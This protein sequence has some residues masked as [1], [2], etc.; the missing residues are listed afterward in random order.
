MI[1]G[2]FSR[3]LRMVSWRSPRLRSC[4]SS[5]LGFVRRGFRGCT[6]GR[7]MDRGSMP[8]W[9]HA[10]RK[11]FWT[12]R[13]TWAGRQKPF[14]LASLKTNWGLTSASVKGFDRRARIFSENT[15]L[16]AMVCLLCLCVK[17]SNYCTG[18]SIFKGSAT[19]SHCA[20]SFGKKSEL[21]T[22]LAC[23]EYVCSLSTASI[24]PILQPKCI[25]YSTQSI[26]MYQAPR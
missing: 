8:S 25:E 14:C 20:C 26:L 23:D 21:P 2:I 13:L 4:F 3:F 24:P 10:L 22:R 19:P 9:M 17:A 11:S 7:P 15:R 6:A 16:L 18:L 1:S 5:L 12:R